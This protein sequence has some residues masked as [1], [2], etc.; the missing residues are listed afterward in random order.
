[1][2]LAGPSGS[3]K[4]S[5]A[6][7]QFRPDQIVS[8]DALR[9]IVG[10]GEHDQRAGTDAFDLANLVVERRLKRGLLTVVDSLG[11]DPKQRARWLKVAATHGRPTVAVA[12][13]VPAAECRK[14]NKQRSSPVPSKALTSQLTRWPEQ[15]NLLD[16]E[17]DK[18]VS[19]GD[20]RIVPTT[21]ARWAAPDKEPRA[22]KFGLTISS[23]T[24]ADGAADLGPK[25][26]A[27]AQEAEAAGFDSLW[28][29]DHFVQIPQ[30]G[31]Q[32]DP[33][34]ESYTALAFLA[35]V[36]ERVSLGTMVTGITYRNI[37]HLAKIV[38][39]LDV[40]SGGRARCGLG[41]AWFDTEHEL[42]G[43]EFPPL[44]ERY[45][46][47]EDALQLLPLMWGPGSPSFE[48]R[49]IST[50][51]AT[52]YPRPVQEHIPMLVG[53]SGEKKTL[54]LVAQY[55][56][57]CNLF[58][59]P[60]VIAHKV[61]VLDDHLATFDRDRSEVAVTQLSGVLCAA[62]DDDLAARVAALSPRDTPPEV[63]SELVTA[64]TVDDHIGRFQALADVGVDEAI[65][66]LA[67]L[68]L[69]DAIS[70]FA[71]VI[72]QFQG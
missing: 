69:P 57:A 45:D 36:T 11:L 43:Y 58:G 27:L 18:V 19:P 28:V 34:L 53:G 50:P 5:W 35:G 2:V 31:R 56:D 55:A 70:N 12:F 16:H 42:Y 44:A 49:T 6:D 46:Q 48:G 17:F 66:A 32:W 15:L 13:D 64:G 60:D 68:S 10:F 67:D 51:A 33:M 30:V 39:T 20:V 37:A 47:L 8:T 65:V 23:F 71:P 21:L 40:L 41:A 61:S 26:A 22:M 72:Q 25:L 59:E 14:R 9:A 62:S 38:A 63:V 4:S 3:G 52:C 1:M 29:M 24:F 7:S 54:K